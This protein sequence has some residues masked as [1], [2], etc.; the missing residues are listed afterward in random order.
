MT[1]DFRALAASAS[2]SGRGGVRLATLL[3][4]ASAAALAAGAAPSLAA[5]ATDSAPVAAADTTAATGVE[6]I[7]VTAQRREQDIKSIPI[8]I[9]A[10]GGGEVREQR[11]TDFDDLSRNV[12]GVAFDS[13]GSEGTTNIS[14]RGVSSTAG[15]ATVGLYID[16]VSITVKNLFY[17]GSVD[18]KLPDLDRIEVLRGPQGTLYGDSSEGGTIRYIS[19]APN[20]HAYSGEVSLDTSNTAHGGENYSGGF[21]L[22]L[23]LIP[24]KLAVRV[25]GSAQTDSGWIDHYTQDLVDGAPV[26]GGVLDQ[27]G[28]N[29]DRIETAHV[30]VKITPGDGFT[31]TPALFYQKV[32]SNDTSAFYLDTPGLGLYDQDK[33]VREFGRDSVLLTSLNVRKSLGFADFTSVTGLFQRD[34]NRQEDGTFFNST[35]FAEDF[36]GALPGACPVTCPALPNPVNPAIS[37]QQAL[38]IMGNLPSPVKLKTTYQQFTQE[39]RLSSPDDG[40]ASKVHWVAGL[41]YAQ[42]TVHNTDFQQIPG[43]NSTFLSLYGETLEQSSAET[44][45]NGGIPNTVLFPNDIDESDNRTYRETQYAAFGQVDYDPWPDWHIGVGARYEIAA[46]HFDS[47]EIGFY[48][49]GNISPYHQEAK[50]NSFTPKLTLS[51]DFTANETVYA[52]AGEGFRLGGPTGPI[53][54][55]PD[56]V[57]AGDFAAINQTTQPTHFGSDN[58]WTYEVGSKGQYFDHRLSLNAAAFYTDWH[59]IQQQIYLPTC[60]YYFTENVGD[61]RIYGGE[62]EA[63]F[64]V[65]AHLKL[66]ASA[67]AESATISRSINPIDV[68]VGANLIDVPDGAFTLGAS[69]TTPV[70]GAWRLTARG[71]YAWT[72]HSYGS[73]QATNADYYNPAYGVVNASVLLTNGDYDVSLYAKNLLDDHTVIQTPEINTVVEAYTVHPREIGVTLR[74]R[75]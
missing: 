48:Q 34:H 29:S 3:T 59:N 66:D 16:D 37:P 68:P 63:T 64:K 36:L 41:Y 20:M 74:A 55:G 27:K 47:T 45:F 30:S 2:R 56:T 44:A 39:L 70:T 21:N 49:I 7:V 60:G 15:S 19:Q 13:F 69:Y 24:D 72:G 42:Q 25:S 4:F 51:H 11:I 17:E 52:S 28:V 26:G 33:Q 1:C 6:E 53:T 14:I 35:V 5:A 62:L 71:E 18:T 73:Y 46:E 9:T 40:A 50:S 54:F 31:I 58:L 43:I 10:L 8:S 12:P 61:G 65:T 67:S 23:P 32:Q 75:F 22:N 38:N 57:C